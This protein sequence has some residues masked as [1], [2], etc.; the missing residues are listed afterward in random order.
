M[1]NSG[2]DS[3]S[4][5][6][7]AMD[8]LLD[9]LM[10]NI[11]DHFALTRKQN[12]KD[13]RTATKLLLLA[14]DEKFNTK[15]LEVNQGRE[16]NSDSLRE[17]IELSSRYCKERNFKPEVISLIGVMD[18]ARF[19]NEEARNKYADGDTS[20]PHKLNTTMTIIITDVFGNCASAYR[21]IIYEDDVE[22]LAPDSE[23][24][25]SYSYTNEKTY[26]DLRRFIAEYF[27]W[28]ASTT[29]DGVP[30]LEKIIED[31]RNGTFQSFYRRTVDLMV[32]DGTRGGPFV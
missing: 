20:V 7:Q 16:V 24:T 14:P 12:M 15:T 25:I 3:K 11:N 5:M 22:L 19:D 32:M 31:I 8:G 29:N 4:K 2:I 30:P 10:K 9:I 1:N 6:G 27:G 21:P 13:Y 28:N 26:G 18:V 23:W 17:F